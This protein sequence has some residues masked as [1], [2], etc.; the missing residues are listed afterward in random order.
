M[1][2]TPVVD[3]V[4]VTVKPDVEDAPPP[5]TDRSGEVP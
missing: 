2:Q 1:V 5:K 4:K 3:E